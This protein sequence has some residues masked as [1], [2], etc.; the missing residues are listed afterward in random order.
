MATLDQASYATIDLSRKLTI[1][2][3]LEYLMEDGRG[4]N[5]DAVE[6]VASSQMK[7]NIGPVT[8]LKMSILKTQRTSRPGF[9]CLFISSFGA[10]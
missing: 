5:R 9:T 8:V 3:I 2:S 7:G 10:K 1:E 4:N 6:V